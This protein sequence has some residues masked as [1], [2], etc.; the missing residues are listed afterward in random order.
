R[1]RVGVALAVAAAA[2][3]AGGC[4]SS[5]HRSTTA[6]HPA[7][8][9]DQRA[10]AAK[11]KP[12]PKPKPKARRIPTVP[13]PR[14]RALRPRRHTAAATGT[15]NIAPGAPSDAEVARE[16]AR[17]MGYSGGKVSPSTVRDRGILQPDG[18]VVPPPSAPYA[19]QAIVTAGNEVARLPYVYG[20]G[21][22]TW[23]DSAYD[24][25][26]SV[27]FA[28][29]NAGFLTTQEDSSQLARFG[30]PGPGRWVTIYANAGH[31]YMVVAGIRFDTSGRS[32]PRGSRWQAAMRTNAGF[33]VRHPPGL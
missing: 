27:S 18:L 17:A 33:T 26:G 12:A 30:A 20:G 16:L 8:A 19:V 25:S 32:G 1:L 24:C 28:L 31:A 13:A 2:L 23:I 7:T 6:S 4:G 21:H 15:S 14:S 29:A 22:G 9:P 10:L 11:S 5:A 3:V